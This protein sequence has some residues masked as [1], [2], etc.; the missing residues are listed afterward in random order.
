MWMLKGRAFDVPEF[1]PQAQG[2]YEDVVSLLEPHEAELS[3][4]SLKKL[5]IARKRVAG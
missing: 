4:S 2:R 5:Q 3:G 1:E